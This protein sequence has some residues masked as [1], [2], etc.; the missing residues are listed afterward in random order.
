MADAD[1]RRRSARFDLGVTQRYDSGG[2]Y[3][4]NFSIDPRPYV[5]NPGYLVP[6]SSVTYYATS[7][8]AFHFDGFWRTDLSLSWNYKI[9]KKTQVFF[10]G[11]VGNVFNNDALQSFNTT[12]THGGDD[13]VQPVH[14]HAGRG[15]EL[16]EGLAFGQPSS[17]SSYQ[18]PRD[19][20]FSVGFRF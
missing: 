1:P 6:P 15:R 20:S 18:A 19:F 11:V 3:D 16:E 10:R 5:T 2:P 14:D 17:P 8:G 4:Y 13:G 9:Y 12:V 7:R